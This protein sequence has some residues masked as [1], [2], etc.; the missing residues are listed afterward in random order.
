MENTGEFINNGVIKK[1][2]HGYIYIKVGLQFIPEHRLV[3]E[4]FLGR[5]L[6]KEEV[7]H[8]LDSN[9]INNELDNLMLFNTQKEHASFHRKI[10]QFGYTRPILR[11][12]ENRWQNEHR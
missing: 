10:K 4:E 11:Q 9:R 7:I 5:T 8:H 3:V 12:I 2:L 6:T 1:K